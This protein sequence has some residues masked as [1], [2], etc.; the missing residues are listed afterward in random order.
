M[1]QH[2]LPGPCLA[3]QR[4]SMLPSRPAAARPSRSRLLSARV[5]AAADLGVQHPTSQDSSSSPPASA[6]P[7]LA[8]SASLTAPHAPSS[9]PAEL[10][11]LHGQNWRVLPNGNTPQLPEPE[12]RWSWNP[13]LGEVRLSSPH[14]TSPHPLPALLYPSP[15]FPFTLLLTLAPPPSPSLDRFPPYLCYTLLRTRPPPPSLDPPQK[16]LCACAVW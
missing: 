10:A 12:G 15:Y 6:C 3:S 7:F 14:P 5:A 9:V 1:L 13:L 8:T 11:G 2:K 16:N 4:G